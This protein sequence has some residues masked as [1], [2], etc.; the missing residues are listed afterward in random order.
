[1]PTM[2]RPNSKAKYISDHVLKKENTKDQER[3]QEQSNRKTKEY[4]QM[5]LR[6]YDPGR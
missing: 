2:P 1:M 5:N 4:V 3:Q 6:D